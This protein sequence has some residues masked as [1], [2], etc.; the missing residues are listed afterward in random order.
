MYSLRKDQARRS[1]DQGSNTKGQMMSREQF[2]EDPVF[3][4]I[5]KEQLR[6]AYL[7]VLARS[8]LRGEARIKDGVYEELPERGK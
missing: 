5:T 6:D 3:A 8:L 7:R 1:D 4:E 2:I